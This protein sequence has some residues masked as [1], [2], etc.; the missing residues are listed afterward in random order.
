MSGLVGNGG[1]IYWV[2]GEASGDRH[3]AEVLRDLRRLDP[4]VQS[5]GVGGPQLKS[6]GQ[7]QLFDLTASAVVGLTEV[8]KNYFKFRAFFHRILED[9]EQVRPDVLLLVDYPGFNLRLAKA[10]RARWP[11]LK[12]IYFISPQVWAWKSGRAKMMAETLDHLM[13]LFPFEVEWFQKHEPRLKVTCVGHPMLDRWHPSEAETVE[14]D[15]PDCPIALLPGSRKREISAHLPMMLAAARELIPAYPNLRFNIL[16]ADDLC[17]EWIREELTRTG[18]GSPVFSLSTGY[19]LTQLNRSRLAWVASGTATVECAV[20]GVP[21]L[22]IYKVN[23]ITFWVGR[24]LV[25]VPHLA[26][27]N[28]LAGEK[29][30]PE[31]LQEKATA[32]SLISATRQILKQPGW[33]SGM[34]AKLASVVEKLGGPGAAHRAAEVIVGVLADLPVRSEPAVAPVESSVHSATNP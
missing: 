34:K 16:A 11:G 21:M 7:N 13:V 12:I 26:M 28:L 19:S 25:K 4:T 17:E 9:I 22:V 33:L 5:F 20:A 18:T 27:V 15:G 8:L 3:A 29:I 32:D 30:V 23:P 24:R 31:F 1:K 14:I 6:A 2:A 10:A